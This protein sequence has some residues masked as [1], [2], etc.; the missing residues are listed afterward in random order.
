MPEFVV[1]MSLPLSSRDHLQWSLSSSFK[2]AFVRALTDRLSIPA[3]RL[4]LSASRASARICLAFLFQVE[5]L[6][7]TRSAPVDT[8]TGLT[9]MPEPPTPVPAV[10][11]PPSYGVAHP[12]A[13]VP[14]MEG[15][16][17]LEDVVP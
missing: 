8:C 11:C 5:V 1:D 12:W 10:R 4:F 15:S 16:V 13:S 17:P 6:P 14:A 9:V 7:F 3:L 2:R